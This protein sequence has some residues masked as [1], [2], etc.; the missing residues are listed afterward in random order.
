MLI[1]DWSSDV[2]ASDL[3]ESQIDR[4]GRRVRRIIDDEHARARHGEAHR[5]LEAF[6]IFVVGRGRHRA[7]RGAGDDE[8]EGV[9]RKARVG[10]EHDIA[11]RGDRGGESREPFT[12]SR[13]YT[14]YDFW[15]EI[16]PDSVA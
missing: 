11:R 10:R 3:V 14:Y 4:L 8:A 7:D 12:R 13:R 16:A 15:T 6:E 5:A 2:C 9:D 1:S